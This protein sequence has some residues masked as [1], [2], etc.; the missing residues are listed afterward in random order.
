MNGYTS[1][2]SALTVEGVK[3]TLPAQPPAWVAA[4][5]GVVRA[6]PPEMAGAGFADLLS[7]TTAMADWAI[8][9]TVLGGWFSTT[10]HEL[11][12][13][14]FDTVLKKAGGVGAAKPAAI[15]A[16]THALVLSGLSM[17]VAG[18]SGPASGGEH[19]ISHYWDM[20]AKTAGRKPAL[21]GCQVAIGTLVSAT[22]HEKLRAHRPRPVTAPDREQW[23]AEV[24]AQFAGAQAD[25]V[26]QQASR[27]YRDQQAANKQTAKLE[28]IWDSCL[29]AAERYL[30]PAWKLQEY[31]TA[32]GAPTRISQIGVSADEMRAALLH[33]RAI[34]DRYTVLHLAADAGLLELLADEVLS[35]SG[36][37]A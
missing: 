36:V 26:V 31:L 24:A 4:D 33:G 23:L 5:L 14:A 15:S 22:L 9:H 32:A 19:L 18:S 37:L 25:Q 6:A 10:P 29:S 21:H 35:D 8:S 30:E 13:L 20:T 27:V 28:R 34:R 1:T 11:V 12:E 16:L 7:K 2:I 3:R 17:A